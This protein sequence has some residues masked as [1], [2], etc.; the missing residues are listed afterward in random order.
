MQ[1]AECSRVTCLAL[2]M[3]SALG[4]LLTTT[5]VGA[6]AGPADEAE[7][8]ASLAG[9][10]GGLVIHV[11]CGD[12]KLTA[13]LRLA[14]NCVVQG[15]E[16]DAKRVQRARAAIRAIGQYG[17]VSV[18]HWNG[19]QLPYVDNLASLVV[20]E[21]AR[22]VPPGCEGRSKSVAPGGPKL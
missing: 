7:Q 12:G 6:L 1:T 21:D 20:C 13:A 18:V 19:K 17:P 10:H 8:I 22:T 3:V 11:G 9:F 4:M 14:E 5:V 16:T 15:L 2:R